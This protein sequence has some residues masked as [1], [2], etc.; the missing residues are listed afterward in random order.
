MSDSRFDG[1]ST[2]EIVHRIQAGES[3]LFG[4]LYDRYFN[5]LRFIARCRLPRR[6]RSKLDSVDLVQSAFRE[7]VEHIDQFQNCRSDGLFLN[8]LSRA[9]INNLKNKIAH[10][11]C[12]KADIARENPLEAEGEEKAREVPADAPGVVSVAAMLEDLGRLE[13]TLDDIPDPHREVIL[14][15]WFCSMT[16][17]EVGGELSCTPG[18]A[19]QRELKALASLVVHWHRRF[20]HAPGAA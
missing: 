14:L 20:G 6:L 5:R 12:K 11:E 3:D 15:R 16:W 9:M 17:E 19:K 8:W 10:F 7:A 18:A 13:T 1:A 2:Q 4:V